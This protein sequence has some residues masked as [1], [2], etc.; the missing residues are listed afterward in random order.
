MKVGENSEKNLFARHG[1]RK[2]KYKQPPRRLFVLQWRMTLPNFVSQLEKNRVQMLCLKKTSSTWNQVVFNW[3]YGITPL[4][5]VYRSKAVSYS[6]QAVCVRRK[7]ERKK[8]IPHHPKP[9]TKSTAARRRRPP[10]DGVRRITSHAW[11][12]TQSLPRIPGVWK[13]RS[14]TALV[15][16]KKSRMSHMDRQTNLM[17]APCTHSVM[18]RL[19]CPL[20]KKRPRSLRSLGLASLQLVIDKYCINVIYIRDVISTREWYWL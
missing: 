16:I 19:F 4:T 15:I 20:G 18:K 11:A 6:K 1:L 10:R 7:K 14:R 2:I 13:S 12:Y 17:M 8:R 5:L 3:Y 9:T